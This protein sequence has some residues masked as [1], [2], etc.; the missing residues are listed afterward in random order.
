MKNA[1]AAIAL[2]LILLGLPSCAPSERQFHQD[3][4]IFGT[5]IGVTLWHDDETAAHQ[6]FQDLQGRFMEMHRDWH[7]WEPGMLTEIN[8]AFAN[9]ETATADEDILLMIRRSQEYERASDGRFNPAIGGLIRLWGFHTSDYPVLGPPPSAESIA[10]LLA[11][12]PSSLDIRIDGYA[13]QSDNP[14]VL[15]DFG[16]IAKGLAIDIA[17]SVL[18][19]RGIEN[20]IVNA[21]GD[22]RAIGSHGARPW[23]IAVRAP[24]GGVVASIETGRDEAIFTSGNYERFREDDQERYPHILDPR[25][26]WPVTDLSSVTVITTE[27]ILADAAATAITVAGLNDW[28][29]VA[30]SMGTET[31]MVIDEEGVV[32]M[33]RPMSERAEMLEEVEVRIFDF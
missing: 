17:C 15:L 7:A 8:E 20:A 27:G 26:G 6:A 1:Y 29:E 3:F 12:H 2:I 4:F 14:A 5:L 21:G 24:G 10:G 33:T 11:E 30:R 19:E 18:R 16:G 32:R 13:V 22:L 9:G 25:T 31:V 23:N 28:L